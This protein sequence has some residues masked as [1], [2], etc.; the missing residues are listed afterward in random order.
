MVIGTAGGSTGH[1][2]ARISRVTKENPDLR[3]RLRIGVRS[4]RDE[5]REHLLLPLH[6]VDAEE[7]GERVW[8]IALLK[9]TYGGDVARP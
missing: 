5:E 7:R 6:E 1:F 4:A 2:I 9:G 8:V 3:M